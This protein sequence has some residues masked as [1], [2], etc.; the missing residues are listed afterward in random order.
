VKNYNLLIVILVAI[1]SSSQLYSQD[2]PFEY[3]NSSSFQNVTTTTLL[4]PEEMGFNKSEYLSTNNYLGFEILNPKL[5]KGWVNESPWVGINAQLSYLRFGFAMGNATK[6]DNGRTLRQKG[7]LINIGIFYNHPIHVIKNYLAIEPEVGLDFYYGQFRDDPSSNP[8][9]IGFGF[10]PGLGIKMGPVK[11]V[12]KYTMSFAANIFDKTNAWTG[13]FGYLSLGAYIETGWGLMNPKLIQSK[14]YLQS[15]SQ[16]REYIGGEYNYVNDT[17]YSV[18]KVTTTYQQHSVKGAVND[19]GPFWYLSP[20]YNSSFVI[21]RDNRTTSQ[22]GGALGFRSG[23]FGGEAY[24]QTGKHGFGN[25]LKDG[26]LIDYFNETKDHAGYVNST[27]FGGQL[28]F[29]FMGLL[30]KIFVHE[31][32]DRSIYNAT[33]FMRVL[34]TGGYGYTLFSGNPIYNSQS[35]QT[36]MNALLTD[37]PELTPEIKNTP[38]SVSSSP[39]TSIGVKLEMG[40]VSIGFEKYTYKKG[41]F[42]N[43]STLTMSYLIPPGRI[44]RAM[45][46]RKMAKTLTQPKK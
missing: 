45:K 17:W 33:R 20:K 3:P 15:S 25:Q 44:N 22:M 10:T 39:H 18:Y 28:G 32:E 31:H 40:L 46:V 7:H 27:S 4:S 5:K 13:G 38:G 2:Q 30:T 43:G 41:E 14:G 35:A 37:H 8:A 24:V 19:V 9:G 26:D 12:G 29:E 21:S 23:I 11:V 34:I 16:Y 6:D 1:I 42:A 36:E